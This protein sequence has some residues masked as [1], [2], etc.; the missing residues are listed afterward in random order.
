MKELSQKYAEE[1]ATQH[2]ITPAKN[3][4]STTA[5]S[6]T[7]GARTTA[8]N[9]ISSQAELMVPYTLAVRGG[10]GVFLCSSMVFIPSLSHL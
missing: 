5:S 4:P 2:S 7:T 3:I 8:P 6:D 10:H 9:E 1:T